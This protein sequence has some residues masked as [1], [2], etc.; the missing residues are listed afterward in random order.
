MR[1]NPSQARQ[2]ALQGFL[3]GLLPASLWSVY[4]E[5]PF[6]PGKSGILTSFLAGT[7]L[8]AGCGLLFRNRK[9]GG[10]LI[11]AGILLNLFLLFFDFLSNH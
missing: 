7:L 10:L 8:L 1:K 2:Y 11:S 4:A 6:L 9:K 5:N 3:L